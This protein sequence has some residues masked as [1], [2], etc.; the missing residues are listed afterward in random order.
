MIYYLIMT[1]F[2]VSIDSFACGL[3][4]SLGKNKTLPLVIIVTI[5]VFLMCCISNYATI[6]LKGFFT[7]KSVGI[8]GIILVAIGIFNLLKKENKQN[9]SKNTFIYQAITVGFAV[10]LDGAFANLSLSLMGINAFYVPIVI[11]LCH[12]LMIGLS[13]LIS[14]TKIA[15]KISKLSFVSP[16]ILIVLGLYKIIGIFI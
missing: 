6:L 16:I 14:Q 15:K 9:F 4:L 7:E 8:G 5:T 2:T 11:A 12:G 13:I 10:G 3:S 1:A